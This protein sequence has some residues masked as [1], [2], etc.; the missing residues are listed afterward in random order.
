MTKTY[1]ATTALHQVSLSVS[2][3]A[4]HGLVGE[5]G[6]GKSTLGKIV[7]GIVRPD[8][9]TVEVHGRRVHYGSPRDAIDDGIAVMGQEIA[10]V[11][12]M[13]VMENVFLGVE[14]RIQKGDNDRSWDE[15]YRELTERVG[16][17]P[18]PR[19]RVDS[20]S[21]SEQQQVQ[22][23]RALARG[24][25][26]LV[27][28]EPT[29]SQHR[30]ELRK[31]HKVF[32]ELRDDGMT[33]I[34]VSHFLDDVVSLADDVTILRSGQTVGTVKATETTPDQ[35]LRAMLGQR[36][37]SVFPQR[38]RGGKADR[39]RALNVRDLSQ[40][41]T[42]KDI[43]LDVRRGEI[44]GLAGLVGSGR[45][46]LA[47]SIF[48]IDGYDEGEV[49]VYDTPLRRHSTTSAMRAGVALVPE[50]RMTQGLLHNLSQEANIALPH[51]NNFSIGGVVRQRALRR[52]TLK[53]AT[54][55]GVSPLRL[56]A[57][58]EILSGGN[59][60][61]VLLAKWLLGEPKVLILD[62][63]T[64]GVDIGAKSSIYH[65]IADLADKQGMAVLLISSELEEIVELSDRVFVMHEGSVA[66]TLEG[67]DINGE[68]I[69]RA[70]FGFSDRK[71]GKIDVD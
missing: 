37:T 47:R 36:L 44:V 65:L 1:G 52:S 40:A 56:G 22:I 70:A 11:P 53:Y 55:S 50:D 18:S 54:Q 6:A 23:L 17:H 16:F 59:Q 35:L 9:G 42:L 7:G 49:S 21:I 58:P 60:Q 48:G 33:I 46:E 12:A 57:R 39:P 24:A 31:L 27:M 69:M 34:Y 13:S 20:L 45:T 67:S 41:G 68:A 25:S 32:A 63:P 10:L 19:A 51:L 5:N 4:I 14:R 62:E 30:E 15:V 2:T 29:S 3:G 66:A 26:I 71:A 28:D 64:R 61:K 8:H 43:D 38:H